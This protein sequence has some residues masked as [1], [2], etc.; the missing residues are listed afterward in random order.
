M[1]K[2][3]KEERLRWVLPIA[4]KEVR[5]VDVAKV[6]PHGQRT[7]ERWIAAYKERGEEGLEPKSTRP[8]T[9]PRETPI[10]VKER[11]LEL[12]KATKECALKLKWDLAEE[13]IYLHERT[14]GKFIKTEGL[15]RRYRI[16]KI[17]YKY[18]RVPLRSGELVEIDVKYV[19]QKLGNRQYYQYTAID[20]AS[21][22][23]Y[24]EAY[25]EQTKGATIDFLGKVIGR[26]PGKIVA[27]KT[28]NHATFTNRYNGSYRSDAPFPSLHALDEFC[29]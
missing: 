10:R 24:L 9:N 3:T 7:L 8:K 12:R 16:R 6:C 27:I 11:A 25:E 4:N 26:F 23:R 13:G 2:N 17:H 14:I 15:T 22:W 28:D 19:P 18:V 21:R 5:L 29:Q 20:V 1:P